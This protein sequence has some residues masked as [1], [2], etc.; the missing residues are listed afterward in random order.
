MLMAKMIKF[1]S[2][3][4]R[5][6]LEIKRYRKFLDFE[7]FQKKNKM[8]CTLIRKTRVDLKVDTMHVLKLHDL[9]LE[10]FNFVKNYKESRTIMRVGL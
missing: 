10:I 2:N 9:P 7:N 3:G 4:T 5:I 6:K 8:C 1:S